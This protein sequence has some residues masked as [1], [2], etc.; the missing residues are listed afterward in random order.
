MGLYV[1]DFF[2]KQFGAL[3]GLHSFPF[4]GLLVQSG[5]FVTRSSGVDA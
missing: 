3:V 2:G 5:D 4:V 1:F